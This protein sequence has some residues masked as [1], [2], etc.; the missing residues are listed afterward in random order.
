MSES[1]DLK[2]SAERIKSQETL[3][4]MSKYLDKVIARVDETMARE[5]DSM[6]IYWIVWACWIT[7]GYFSKTGNSLFEMFFIFALIYNALRQ[8]L[9]ARAFGEFKG[10]VKTLEILGMIPPIGPRGDR[11][12]KKQVWSEG[13]EI[14][15]GWL[16][17]K[18][19]VQDEAYAPA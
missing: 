16:K 11:E 2:K 13:I 9:R 3:D 7:V 8:S 4:A 15:K 10:C 18:E 1:E 12:K 14:V 6:I 17:K 5:K 19:K